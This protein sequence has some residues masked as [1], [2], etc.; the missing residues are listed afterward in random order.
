MGA[1]K[2]GDHLPRCPTGSAAQASALLVTVLRYF[3]S[4][5]WG[6]E[7]SGKMPD[8]REFETKLPNYQ[9]E[10]VMH[11]GRNHSLTSVKMLYFYVM[12]AQ[13]LKNLRV[14]CSSLDSQ[15]IRTLL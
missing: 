3:S 13:I 2:T 1:N 10:A 5:S 12:S 4:P 7:S 14:K 11:L 15:S 9:R 8:H 6:P